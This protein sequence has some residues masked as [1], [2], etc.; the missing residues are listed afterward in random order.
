MVILLLLLFCV[1]SGRKFPTS[2]WVGERVEL[3]ATCQ[4]GRSAST[5][6]RVTSSRAPYDSFGVM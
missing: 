3:S 2:I 4:F 1:L 6:L 5:T